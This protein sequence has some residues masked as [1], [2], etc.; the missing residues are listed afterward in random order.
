ML[1][2]QH[3]AAQPMDER[4]R[5][6]FAFAAYNAGPAA[7]ERMREEARRE[8]RDPKVWFNQVERVVAQQQGRQTVDYVRNIYKYYVAY[9]LAREANLARARA[10]DEVA[11]QRA[12]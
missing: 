4:D 10:G 9:T 6:L 11:K 7:I 2:D 5:L 8:G 12:R 1:I 3:F